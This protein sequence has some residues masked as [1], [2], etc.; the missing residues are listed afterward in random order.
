MRPTGYAVKHQAALNTII[1]SGTFS[2]GISNVLRAY[3]HK[4]PSL[5]LESMKIAA[6]NINVQKD[7]P[8]KGKFLRLIGWRRFSSGNG[9]SAETA[10]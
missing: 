4:K 1:T 6:T 8:S 3:K 7:F 5:N 9:I 2:S 10:E